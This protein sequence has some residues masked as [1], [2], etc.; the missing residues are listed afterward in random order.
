VFVCVCNRF[1]AARNHRALE[2][3]Q[4]AAIFVCY[5]IRFLAEQTARELISHIKVCFCS[6]ADGMRAIQ[7]GPE[8]NRF[9][10]GIDTFIFVFVKV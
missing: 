4:R 3:L 10:A 6:F 8:L 7:S 1:H 5:W 9:W 2:Y